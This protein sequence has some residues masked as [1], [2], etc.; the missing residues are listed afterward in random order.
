MK[1]YFLIC[2]SLAYYQPVLCQVNGDAIVSNAV[3]QNRRTDF[4]KNLQE[5]IIQKTFR[6]NF[7]PS[8]DNLYREACWAISQFLIKTQETESGLK[9]LMPY[10]NN[11]SFE[12]KRALLEAIF[13]VFPIQFKKQIH[14]L[15][16]REKMPKLF[17]M[18]ALYLY[19]INPTPVFARFIKRKIEQKFTHHERESL[20]IQLGNYLDHNEQY[21]NSLV[22][23]ISTLFLNQEKLKEK[24][25][26]SFQRWDRNYPGLAILQLADG[27]FYKDSLGRLIVFEQ[28][29]RSAAN[30]PYFITNG[31][32]PQGLYRITGT[33]ISNNTF[34]GPTPNLQLIMPFEN[35]TKFWEGLSFNSVDTLENYLQ[36]FP[37]EWHSYTPI[38]ES[39][40]AGKVGRTEII[41]HGTTID[42]A[43]FKQFPFYPLTPTLGCLCAKE[44]WNTSSGKFIESDQ[45]QLAAGFLSTPGQGGYLVVINL[46][47]QSKK[48]S[49][50]EVEA[51]VLKMEKQLKKSK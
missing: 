12:T 11:L 37:T 28:L 20:L 40:F 14:E 5:K 4:D 48:V 6:L 36:F 50:S 49:Y 43:Y 42:P 7:N 19:K 29:A 16:S 35:D 1:M 30:L 21:K 26:Y 15:F 46:D 9:S 24:V 25:I 38:T 31:N 32:T 17:A 39:F 41:A 45:Y 27:R 3:L 23:D 44:I 13:G 51:W 8:N 18:E 34:I 22:P 47:N 10:F 2:L 33:E